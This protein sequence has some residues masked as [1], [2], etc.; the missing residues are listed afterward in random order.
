MEGPTE[1]TGVKVALAPREALQRTA[2]HLG[3]ADGAEHHAR[4]FAYIT[5]PALG[6]L[7]DDLRPGWRKG[8]DAR[9]DLAAL[10]GPG[11][12]MA[13]EAAAARYGGPAVAAE[14]DAR[15]AK[16]VARVAALRRRFVEGPT[17]SVPMGYITFNPSLQEAHAGLGIFNPTLT[18]TA[19]WGTL[20]V[21]DGSLMAEDWKQV[22][23]EAPADALSPPMAGPGWTL[24][25]KEG[26]MLAPGA[27]K[28]DWVVRKP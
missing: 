15:E 7:L 3:E 19:P 9:A 6:L 1:Y 2:Q 18:L 11:D 16:R 8:L 27:R 12:P 28:G 25:V 10:L 23:V 24:E 13:A 17:L 4:S 22:T 21:T 20:T 5:G 14:E 26:W